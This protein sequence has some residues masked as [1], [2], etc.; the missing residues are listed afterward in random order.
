MPGTYGSSEP[1]VPRMVPDILRVSEVRG[2]LQILYKKV[3]RML[4]QF[5]TS[6][7]VSTLKHYTVIVNVNLKTLQKVNLNPPCSSTCYYY[8]IGVIASHCHYNGP[9][10]MEWSMKASLNVREMVRRPPGLV[11][12]TI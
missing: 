7:I 2:Q 11:Q 4:R 10:K 3:K 1:V 12:S 5:P 9:L 6:S 8:T